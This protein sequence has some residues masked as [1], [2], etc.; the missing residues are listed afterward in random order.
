M[1]VQDMIFA[2]GM[3]IS[4]TFNTIASKL[5]D[6]IEAVGRPNHPKH[7]FDHPGV[8]TLAMFMG[9][10]MCM[11][12]FLA[13]VWRVR[14]AQMQRMQQIQDSGAEKIAQKYPMWT[15]LP[16]AMC[17]MTGSTMMYVALL[18]TSP[19]VYQ[20]LRG[21]IV[22]FTG[23]LSYFFL[24][25]K[26]RPYHIIGMILIVIGTF[27]VGLSSVLHDTGKYKNPLL[28]DILVVAAQ[29][30]AAVQMVLEEKFIGKYNVH[31]LQVV[32]NE[33]LWGMSI[34]AVL[35][36]VTYF[37]VPLRNHFDDSLDAMYQI[38]NSPKL[39]GTLLGSIFSIAF[40]NFFGI[41][42][43]KY[44]SAT[45]RTTIDATRVVLVWVVSL[46]VKWETFEY[47]QLIGFIILVLG[48]AIFNEIIKLPYI[49]YPPKKETPN[50][51]PTTMPI[52]DPYIYDEKQRLLE[53]TVNQ[54]D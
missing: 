50:G 49:V 36:V 5:Q 52:N 47:L 12:A 35:L 2:I 11:I 23:I 22:V 15:F 6:D 18:Y 28:G 19:S 17:D 29:V 3:L 51:P 42:V 27:I 34:T 26:L 48:T 33:G 7:S 43:T 54:L 25:M 32:G 41:S 38:K 14:R 10:S 44:L 45:H 39:M 16:P 24:H 30:V 4:G 46:V 53:K 20:M 37:I 31:P 8:Q 1:R 21:M 9:E 13:T 40:L